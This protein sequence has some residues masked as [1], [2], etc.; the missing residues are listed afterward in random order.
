MSTILKP[1]P[2]EYKGIIFKSKSEAMYARYLDLLDMNYSLLTVAWI[3]EP[4]WAEVNGWTPDF[5]VIIILYPRDKNRI[6]S[7]HEFYIEYKP[8][9]PT[10]TYLKKCS[11]NFNSLGIDKPGIE[12]NYVIHCVDFWEKK[13]TGY[14][15][16]EKNNNYEISIGKGLVGEDFEIF[17]EA[18]NYRFD[19]KNNNE[20]S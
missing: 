14:D 18:F 12:I 3:Y 9:E 13:L 2:T 17:E 4:K 16:Y 5:Y 10:E 7:I 8:N 15:Y 11:K 19:L 1:V 20:G 6:K